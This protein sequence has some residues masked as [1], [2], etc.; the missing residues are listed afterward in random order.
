MATILRDWSYR[1][2][3]L[4]DGISSLAALTVGGNDRLRRLPWDGLDLPRS[5]Q[6]LDLC[7]GS[8]QATRYLLE[9]F[10]TVTGLDASPLSLERANRTVPR[11]KYVRG[12]AEQMPLEAASFDLVHTSAALHEMSSEQLTQILQEVYRVLKPG[13]YFVLVDFH[14]PQHFIMWPGLALFF[15]LFETETAWN[16]LGV[17]LSDLLIQQGFQVIQQNH[18]AGGS[19]QRIQARKLPLTQD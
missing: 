18:Y 19:L 13:G 9:N 11:A 10:D 2:Q 17:N 12:F 16:F 7:C 15:V 4:Y 6:V 14:K 5:V 8:G 1:Y 3:W